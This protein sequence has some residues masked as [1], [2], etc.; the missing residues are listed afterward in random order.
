M[1]RK[2]FALDESCYGQAVKHLGKRL[3]HV[4]TTAKLFLALCEKTVH[5][6][7][8]SRLVVAPYHRDA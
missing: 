5:R 3:P 8:L 1:Q 7:N 2:N 4:H 6:R